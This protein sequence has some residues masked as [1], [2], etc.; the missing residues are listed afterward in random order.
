M[1]TA[2]KKM[3]LPCYTMGRP[4]FVYGILM[5]KVQKKTKKL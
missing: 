4:N 5:A 2:Q 1:I 3:Q